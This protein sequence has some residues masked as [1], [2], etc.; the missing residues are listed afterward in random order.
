MFGKC[1]LLLRKLRKVIMEIKI[2]YDSHFSTIRQ[3]I[4]VKTFTSLH[5]K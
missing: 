3:E 4:P 5:I 2:C 1:F